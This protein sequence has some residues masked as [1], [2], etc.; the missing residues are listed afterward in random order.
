MGRL[1][2]ITSQFDFVEFDPELHRYTIN[3]QRIPS[4]TGLVEIVSPFPW[5]PY[6]EIEVYRQRGTAVHR[7]VELYVEGDLF[8]DGLDETLAPYLKAWMDFVEHTGF[9]VV[10]SEVKVGSKKRMYGG[11][12]DFVGYF[13]STPTPRGRLALVDIKSGVLTAGAGPQT[14]GYTLAWNENVAEKVRDRYVLQLMP[15]G[16]F[17]LTPMQNP[18]DFRA[19]EAAL[20]IYYWREGQ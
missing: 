2:V 1:S 16:R 10:A 3:G 8:I 12:L 17:S 4:V 6:S 15:D 13:P 11:R 20:D 5:R 19:F 14:A 9:K 18:R 7:M